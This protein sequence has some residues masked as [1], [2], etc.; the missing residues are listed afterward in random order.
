MFLSRL[1]SST[2]VLSTLLGIAHAGQTPSTGPI[3]WKKV[4]A[5]FD[6]G[7]LSVPIDWNKPSGENVTLGMLRFKATNQSK[8][9]GSLFFNPGGPGYNATMYVMAA[10]EAF[11]VLYEYFDIIGLDP[12]GVGLSSPIKCD[13]DIYN[14]RVSPYPT[15]NSGLDALV[16]KYK[17]L[18]ES[19]LKKSGSLVKHMD[20]VSVAKDLEAIRAALGDGKLNYLGLSYGTLIGAMYA[21]L[22]PHNIRAMALDGNMD[23]S[24]TPTADLMAKASAYETELVRFSEWCVLNSTCP[25][26]DTDPLHLFD[27]LVAQGNKK[28]IPAPG[29]KISGT[30]RENVT[31]E[32]LQ[33]NSGKWLWFKYGV[34]QFETSWTDFAFALLQAKEGN[35]TLLS[36]SLAEGPSSN[37]FQ[38]TMIHCGDWAHP[39]NS[40]ADVK[41][42]QQLTAALTPHTGSTAD[43][44]N[45]CIGWPFPQQNKEHT[46]N[47]HGTPRILLT[48]AQYDPSTSYISANGLQQQI[49]NSTLLTRKGDGHTSYFQY[50]ETSR[51]ISSYLIRLTVPEPN[52]VLDS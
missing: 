11:P 37:S 6:R 33:E 40:L 28:P 17:S 48:N 15:T 23:H 36:T 20:S 46:A 50:G 49:S 39:K 10:K 12:R 8:K 31:G 16:K 22:Y 25:L 26:K 24:V 7:E 2:L 21:E 1:F 13:P 29:C 32:E 3:T 4:T 27:E 34:G 52:T 41:Y 35:A 45:Q 51:A 42:K 47:I 30:C 18:G 38:S 14:E 5:E 43:S 44:S 9:L 19:C